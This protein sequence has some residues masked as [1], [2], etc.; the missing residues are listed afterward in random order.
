MSASHFVE[1]YS[2]SPA[3]LRAQTAAAV[4]ET[5]DRRST[6]LLLGL[7]RLPAL[8]DAVISAAIVALRKLRD[9]GG[10]VQLVTCNTSHR[11]HLA[12]IG[13]DRVFDIFA[14]YSASAG[15]SRNSKTLEKTP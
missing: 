10:T 3:G 12:R 6:T 8:D 4:S 14:S 7:D 2:S 5:L 13:L 11:E 1:I 15:K 9:I